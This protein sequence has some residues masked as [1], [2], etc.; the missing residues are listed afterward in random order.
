[1]LFAMANARTASAS[2]AVQ[3]CVYLEGPV[4]YCGI[5]I[6]L[7][8]VSEIAAAQTVPLPQPR[9]A[10]PATTPAEAAKPPAPPLPSA[11]FQRLTPSLAIASALSEVDGPGACGAEDA[12]RLEAIVLADKT[13][14]AITPP[15]VV[16]CELAEA[17]AYWVRE[18]VEPAVRRLGPLRSVDNYASYECRGRNRVVG[19]RLSEHGKANAIDMRSFRLASGQ[20]I[21]LTG[22]QTDKDLRE[23]LKRSTCAR[24]TTVLGP[25]SDGYHEDHVHVDLAE[26]RGGYRICQWDVRDKDEKPAAGPDAVQVPLPRPR[27]FARS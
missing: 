7:V 15:A 18:D 2:V 12:V 24:F 20:L 16:R 25:G 6:L 27:P 23:R 10:S 13:R 1:M 26:R 17:L 8:S 19:A 5:L 4:R 11:C 21:E 14:V 22:V 9:P 3:L